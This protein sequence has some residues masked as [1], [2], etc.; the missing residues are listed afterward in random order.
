MSED[1]GELIYFP[2]MAKGLQLALCAEMSGL[3]WTGFTTE[4]TGPKSWGEIKPTGIA[5]F[6]QMPLLKLPN[7]RVMAQS[8]AIANYIAKK[9]GAALEGADDED[10]ALSQMLMAEAE[11][12]Y[13]MLGKCNL[14]NW[15]SVEEREAGAE[16]AKELFAEGL[17]AHFTNLENLARSDVSD[18][19]KHSDCRFTSVSCSSLI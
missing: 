10:F 19:G 5:P 16:A 2:V 8:V 12:I 15:K 6:G 1:L 17:P 11:D 4:E 7:G 13:S 14:A 18:E 3:N 9:A